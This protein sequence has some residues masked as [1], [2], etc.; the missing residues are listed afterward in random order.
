[1]NSIGLIGLGLLGSAIRERL[2]AQGFHVVGYD[3]NGRGNAPTALEV[4]K[5]TRAVVLSLP[6]SAVSREVLAEIEAVLQIGDTIIDTSTGD[7]EE[8]EAIGQHLES[9]GIYYLDATIGG[10]SEQ[11]R[12]QEAIALVGGLKPAFDS[13]APIPGFGPQ[14]RSK[15]PAVQPPS[16]TP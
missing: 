12:R 16:A 6:T 2:L 8:V 7:P 1:M 15:P 4:V 3:I 9:K 5:Q 10:S 13:V 14:K 11:V